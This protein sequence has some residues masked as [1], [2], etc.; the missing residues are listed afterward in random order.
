MGLNKVRRRLAETIG[1]IGGFG[2]RHAVGLDHLVARRI[3]ERDIGTRSAQESEEEVKAARRG[4][5][6]RQLAQVPLADA[7]GDVTG[8]LAVLDGLRAVLVERQIV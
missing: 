8:A 5:E 1:G 3:A 7:T 6:L 4:I 2:R